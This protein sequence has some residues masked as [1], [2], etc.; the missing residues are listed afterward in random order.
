MNVMAPQQT[1]PPQLMPSYGIAD[2]PA[3]L[4]VLR[5]FHLVTLHIIEA[6]KPTAAP[7]M[8]LDSEQSVL[9]KSASWAWSIQALD[10]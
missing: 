4:S 2:A 5:A 6:L 1:A 10:L 7:L 8:Y 3:E 9:F